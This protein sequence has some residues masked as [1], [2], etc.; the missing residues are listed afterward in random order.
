VSNCV[1]NLSPRKDLVLAEVYRILKPGGEFYFSD[2]FADRRLPADVVAN[3]I[4]FAECLGGAM[5]EFDFC[6]LA[7]TTGFRDP[8]LLSRAPIEIL[9]PD[10]RRK[11]GA[12]R[13][14]SSTLRLFKLD[15]LDE[16]CE[17][18]G[19]IATYQGSIDEA[20]ALF[21]LD[22]HH[23]FEAGRAERVCGNTAEMLRNTRLGAHFEVTGT[24]DVH[25]GVFEC[26][27]TIASGAYDE[28]DGDPN[29]CC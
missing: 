9:S 24:R 15:G 26:A 23:V 28:P 3:P 18:Y 22:D 13:F 4:L 5:Y 7:K 2:V 12:A 17:D 27:A 19:Q 20:G 1:V 8:R 14:V 29:N 25:Y 16:R 6:T 10:I 21:R 11:V